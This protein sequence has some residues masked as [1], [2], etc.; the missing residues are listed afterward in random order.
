MQRPAYGWA[1]R[2]TGW[3]GQAVSAGLTAA[4]VGYASSVAV[5][6]TGLRAA[7]ASPAQATFSSM[8][9]G[10]LCGAATMVGSLVTRIPISIVWSSPGLALLA[11][12]HDGPGGW[13]TTVGAFVLTGVAIV[14]TRLIRPLHTALSALPPALL[15]AVL[16]GIL[17]PFCLAPLHALSAH[18][19]GASL[20]VLSWLAMLWAALRIAAPAALVALIAMVLTT[21]GKTTTGLFVAP[22]FA[23]PQFSWHA[24][25]AI[26]LPLYLVTMTGQNLVGAAVL[27]SQGYRTPLPRVLLLTGGLS[28]MAAP[29]GS[30]P[31]NLAALTAAMTAGPAAHPDVDRRWQAAAASGAGF[32]VLGACAPL[33][34]GLIARANPVLVMAAAGLGLLSVFSASAAESFSP[35]RSRFAATVAFLIT[36][37]GVAIGGLTSAPLGLLAGVV[38]FRLDIGARTATRVETIGGVTPQRNGPAAH[39]LIR[40]GRREPHVRKRSVRDV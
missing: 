4:L 26:A 33:T 2:T 37:S 8:A 25:V 6:I 29:L 27:G 28:A 36:A 3:S 21:S 17:L 35:D 13:P 9:A 1:V 18:P 32:F 34:T 38:L 16:A 5:V 10:M 7:G 22:Q 20:I 40:M 11:V 31:L 30:P 15:S 23:S 24:T 39:A 19:G 12:V 14:A